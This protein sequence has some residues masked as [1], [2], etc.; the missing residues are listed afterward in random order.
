MSQWCPSA[1]RR[2]SCP[3][4]PCASP[5]HTTAQLADINTEIGSLTNQ[6][7]I[8]VHTAVL[9]TIRCFCTHAVAWIPSC[10]PL[11]CSASKCKL[12]ARSHTGWR[13]PLCAKP[14]AKRWPQ[15]AQT[16][17]PDAVKQSASPCCVT[18]AMPPTLTARYWYTTAVWEDEE[19]SKQRTLL[20]YTPLPPQGANVTHPCDLACGPFVDL[21]SAY[22]AIENWFLQDGVGFGKEGPNTHQPAPRGPR[23]PSPPSLTHTA[24]AHPQTL[25]KL[26]LLLPLS[27]LCSGP[28]PC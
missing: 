18:S 9:C 7:D 27:Q 17:P 4:T 2:A 1:T 25:S 15:L 6:A 21:P 19:A 3:L 8:L 13:L 10:C 23:P 26:C 5:T 16:A 24:C 22:T 14:N 20:T 11:L 12:A 28:A